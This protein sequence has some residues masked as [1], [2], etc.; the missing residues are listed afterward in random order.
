ML[1]FLRKLSKFLNLQS[2]LTQFANE[3]ESDFEMLE[4]RV[5]KVCFDIFDK[6]QEKL[7]TSSCLSLNLSRHCNKI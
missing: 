4:R 6:L 5:E 2:C 1:L 3:F 7:K